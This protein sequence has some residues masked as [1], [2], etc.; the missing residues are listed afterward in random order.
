MGAA[1]AGSGIVGGAPTSGG[2]TDP[3]V[4][5]PVFSPVND[6]TIR[7]GL[8]AGE[9]IIAG[10]I[11]RVG[12]VLFFAVRARA[13]TGGFLIL[14]AEV[15]AIEEDLLSTCATILLAEE[16]TILTESARPFSLSFFPSAFA[17]ASVG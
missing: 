6:S 8:S 10:C 16:P 4:V 13:R 5:P 2:E 12:P 17:P 1:D 14:W 11:D 15:G 3:V 7:A 9:A